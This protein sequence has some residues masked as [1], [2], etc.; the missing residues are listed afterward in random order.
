MASSSA[1]ELAEGHPETRKR[2][3]QMVVL[4]FSQQVHW[5]LAVCV[6]GQGGGGAGGM[7]SCA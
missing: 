2:R 3:G 5:R 7:Q 6:W 4:T 1:A